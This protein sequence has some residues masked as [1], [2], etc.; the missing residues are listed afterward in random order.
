M[1]AS[2]FSASSSRFRVCC[3]ERLL[4]RLR[5]SPVVTR[6][7]EDLPFLWNRPPGEWLPER[8]FIVDL[9]S[10]E[11]ISLDDYAMSSSDT[12]F[13]YTELSLISRLRASH[14]P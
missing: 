7:T 9:P 4:G 5:P 10:L 2:W 14:S 3:G 13:D 8:G 1:T 11:E 6:W 12:A